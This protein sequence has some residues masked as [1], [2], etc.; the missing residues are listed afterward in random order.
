[1]T[2]F[3]AVIKMMDSIGTILLRMVNMN[4]AE[5]TIPTTTMVETISKNRK[6]IR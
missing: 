3:A 6:K 5:Y 1:M 2:A 4:L